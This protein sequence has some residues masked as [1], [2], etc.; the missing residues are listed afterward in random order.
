MKFSW[1]TL[2]IQYIDKYNIIVITEAKCWCGLIIEVNVIDYPVITLQTGPAFHYIETSLC[3]T[4]T[5]ELIL[6]QGTWY[7]AMELSITVK[8]LDKQKTHTVTCS[9]HIFIINIHYD[10]DISNLFTFYFPIQPCQGP[11]ILITISS[12]DKKSSKTVHNTCHIW[13]SCN[14][15]QT[16]QT[17]I[18]EKYA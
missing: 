6:E 11:S 15:S 10:Q 7:M 12:C 1:S 3:L 18:V 2:M 4:S 17:L 8:A 13:G 14:N 16:E 5:Q 9:S